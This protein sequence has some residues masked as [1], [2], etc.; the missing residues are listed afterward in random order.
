MQLTYQLDESSSMHDFTDL[1]FALD[2]TQKTSEKCSH[3]SEYFSRASHADSAW[4]LYFLMGQRLKGTVRTADLKRWAWQISELPEWLFAECYDHVGDLAETLALVLFSKGGDGNVSGA[5]QENKT[6]LKSLSQLIEEDLLSLKGM[7]AEAQRVVVEGLWSA[8][9]KSNVLVLNK[10]LTGGF[11]VGVSKSLVVKAL[12]Q[13]AGVEPAVMAHKLMGQWQPT[14]E[15]FR[16][17]FAAEDGAQAKLKPYPFCLAYPLEFSEDESLELL[18]GSSQDW[19]IEPKWDGIRAQI[20]YREGRCLI[21]SRGEQLL[22]EQVPEIERA[23]TALN[24]SFILDG[25]LLVWDF[26]RERVRSFSDLQ[27]R[28]GRKKVSDRLE[29]DLPIIFMVYDLLEWEGVQYTL[30]STEERRAQLSNCIAEI[31]SQQLRLSPV[32]DSKLTWE[33]V[34]RERARSRE[35]GVE[36]LMLKAK[37]A[38]YA[39]GRKKGLWWKWKVEPYRV[40]AVLVYAQQGH[41]RRAGIY[42]DYTFS[43]WKAGQLVPF[44]KAYSGLDDATMKRVDQWI[45]AHTVAKHGPVRVVD[46]KLVFEIAFEG[47]QESKRHKSGIAVRFPRM[48]RWRE[49]KP[50]DEADSLESVRALLKV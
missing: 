49:D 46:P 14:E 10:L 30:R 27:K 24:T 19:Q 48:A 21:W 40:D 15:N 2:R 13:I 11:R 5:Y 23:V 17:L 36:G 1:F 28:L 41:G 4:A 34:A 44:C 45:R 22:N 29:K 3:L 25:E 38:E 32:L 16:S 43:I 50:A 12:A 26:E 7:D 8:L 9:D 37:A 18:L 33:S 20:V 35:R 39:V 42:S 6:F 47:I 31:D